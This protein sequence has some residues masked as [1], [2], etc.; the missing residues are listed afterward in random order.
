MY[1]Y[2]Y[3]A[4]LCVS[5]QSVLAPFLDGRLWWQK[6]GGHNGKDLLYNRDIII[7]MAFIS[8]LK[9]HSS[10]EAGWWRSGDL[11]ELK[12][13]IPLSLW[14]GVIRKAVLTNPSSRSLLHI[15]PIKLCN[16]Y[17]GLDFTSPGLLEIR[18]RSRSS[19]PL[20][21]HIIRSGAIV[22]REMKVMTFE[23]TLLTER[24]VAWSVPAGGQEVRV[25]H[26]QTQRESRPLL[27]L[28]KAGMKSPNPRC[29]TGPP[30]NAPPLICV[31]FI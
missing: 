30:G 16:Y 7:Q 29:E 24:R 10:E 18:S 20:F 3:L 17:F 8:P 31:L 15:Q 21:C 22:W 11:L 1:I 4:C 2:Y 28:L 19:L 12:I 25:T 5:A 9:K 6:N 13:N 14:Q 26:A 27:S 23:M